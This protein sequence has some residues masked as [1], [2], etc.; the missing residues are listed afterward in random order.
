[1]V[2]EAIRLADFEFD[3]FAF[4][5][6]HKGPIVPLEAEEPDSSSPETRFTNGPA[7]KNGFAHTEKDSNTAIKKSCAA[8]SMKRRGSRGS[9]E[10]RWC[11]SSGPRSRVLLE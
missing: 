9:G 4:Q 11:Q 1:M 5:A 2:G 3:R 6:C 10:R 8:R 7:A